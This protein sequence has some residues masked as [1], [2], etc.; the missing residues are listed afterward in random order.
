MSE[1]QVLYICDRMKC[2]H[3]SN[4]CRHTTDIKHAKN[5]EVTEIT[6][7]DGTSR[8]YVVENEEYTICEE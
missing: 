6:K 5:F 1:I 2:E 7:F 4:E 3:C 8:V